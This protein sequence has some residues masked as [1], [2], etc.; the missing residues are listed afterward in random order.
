MPENLLRSLRDE[1]NLRSLAG[2]KSYERGEG[3]YRQGAVRS[4]ITHAGK[5]AARVE[6]TEDYTVVLWLEND[7]LRFDCSCP[8]GDMSEFCKH[9]VATA[10]TYVEAAS[11]PATS[12]DE[13]ND[14][15][16]FDDD[17]DFDDGYDDAKPKIQTL[18]AVQGYL[19]SC[20]K[21][22]LVELLLEVAFRS[23]EW[24]VRL[25]RKAHERQR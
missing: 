24:R 21:E 13:D 23:N 16:D 20:R 18:D 14:D 11:A 25:K 19:A 6:G 5:L 4:L 9:C 2:A 7:V 12:E 10:L 1:K 3:Y 15:D 8:M 22:Q 17:E